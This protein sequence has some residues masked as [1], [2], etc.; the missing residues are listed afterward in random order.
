MGVF[1]PGLTWGQSKD[2]NDKNEDISYNHVD[3][4]ASEKGL[5]ACGHG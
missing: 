1:A 3:G 2:D 4:E 5:H